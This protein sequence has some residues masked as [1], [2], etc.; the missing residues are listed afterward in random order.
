MKKVLD[1]IKSALA[2]LA[3]IKAT[4]P[5]A[6]A[7]K[8]QLNAAASNTEAEIKDLAAQKGYSRLSLLVAAAVLG[9]LGFALTHRAKADSFGV[10]NALLGGNA[11]VNSPTNASGVGNGG[12]ISVVNQGSAGFY[13]SGYNTAGTNAT[14][15]YTLGRGFGPTPAWYTTDANGT[16]NGL[17]WETSASL[18]L[19]VTAAQGAWGYVTNLDQTWLK[20][21]NY[22]GIYSTT[23]VAAISNHTAGV[24]KKIIPIR[25]P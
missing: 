8:A 6:D 21:A 3:E 17:Q 9:L 4:G 20:G 7:I 13:A 25:Y 18:T 2:A 5:R 19:T 1:S 22:V 11:I 12:A 23:A 10:T 15:V 14:V 16:V 24:V